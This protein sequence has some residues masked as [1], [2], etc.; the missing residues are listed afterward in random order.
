MKVRLISFPEVL[1]GN[2]WKYLKSV[3][4]V[5]LGRRAKPP[6]S[7]FHTA[8]PP[9]G[10]AGAALLELWPSPGDPALSLSIGSWGS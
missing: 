3:E 4:G 10:Q 2:R 8:V 5:K 1:G 9:S 7:S 6:A